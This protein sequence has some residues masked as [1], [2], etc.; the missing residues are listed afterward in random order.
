MNAIKKLRLK[1]GYTQSEIS[2]ILNISRST[3]AKWETGESKPRAEKL[4]R[5]AKILSCSI[6]DLFKL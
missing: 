4:P 6:D 2:K 3:I 5:L 1:S